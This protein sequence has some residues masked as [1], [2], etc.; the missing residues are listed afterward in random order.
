M[1]LTSA[2]ALK[3]SRLIAGLLL[4]TGSL[5]TLSF[6]AHA[7]DAPPPEA[8]LWSCVSVDDGQEWNCSENE[9]YQ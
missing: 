1:T 3:T 5:L 7:D 8:M 6:T 9:D 2:L 4:M